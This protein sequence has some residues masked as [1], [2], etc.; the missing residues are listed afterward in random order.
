MFA[1]QGFK[2]WLIE[3]TPDVVGLVMIGAVLGAFL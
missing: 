2:V 3:V 1:A